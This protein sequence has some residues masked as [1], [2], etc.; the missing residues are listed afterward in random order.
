MVFRDCGLSRNT[1]C[2]L[3]RC[4]DSSPIGLGPGLARSFLAVHPT[5]RSRRVV[6][7][8]ECARAKGWSRLPVVIQ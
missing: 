7:V 8:P 5:R 6:S 1:R 4:T 3:S 2:M